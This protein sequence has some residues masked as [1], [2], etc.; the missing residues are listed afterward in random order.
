M[1]GV[2][3]VA[4]IVRL[5]CLRRFYEDF[6][7]K[8]YLFSF[9]LPAVPVILTGSI[10][11]YAIHMADMSTVLRLIING[12]TA[13]LVVFGLAYLI[14]LNRQERQMLCNFVKNTFRR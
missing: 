6:S 1:V 9:I 11:A 4:H 14:G 13:P 12:I 5:F 2:C 8:D 3:I 7:L 10:Y